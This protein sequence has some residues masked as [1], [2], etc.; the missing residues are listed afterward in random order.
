MKLESIITKLKELIDRN[1]SKISSLTTS[2]NNVGAV[3]T[4]TPTIIAGSTTLTHNKISSNVVKIGNLVFCEYK[5]TLNSQGSGGV[6]VK[7]FPSL[8]VNHPVGG[9]IFIDG[10]AYYPYHPDADFVYLR[11]GSDGN[12]QGTSVA[13]KVISIAITYTI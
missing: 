7:G 11:N 8:S 3:S 1:T 9:S 2:V 10:Q 6:Y 12:L 4:W 5:G 13:N